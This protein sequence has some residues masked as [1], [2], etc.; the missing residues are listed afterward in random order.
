MTAP[1]ERK[2]AEPLVLNPEKI[3]AQATQIANETLDYYSSDDQFNIEDNR[4][5]GNGSVVVSIDWDHRADHQHFMTFQTLEYTD[6][7]LT[8]ISGEYSGNYYAYYPDKQTVTMGTRMTANGNAQVHMV[9]CDIS[10]KEQRLHEVTRVQ[11][12]TDLR[13][14]YLPASKNGSEGFEL[15]SISIIAR[16]LPSE[17]L[18]KFLPNGRFIALE[19]VLASTIDPYRSNQRFRERVPEISQAEGFPKFHYADTGPHAKQF[20]RTPDRDT[21]KMLGFVHPLEDNP[22]GWLEFVRLGLE[23]N[24]DVARA[25]LVE[26]DRESVQVEEINDVPTIKVNASVDGETFSLSIPEARGSWKEK[27]EE[28]LKRATETFTRDDGTEVVWVPINGEELAQSIQNGYYF[29]D[30]INWVLTAFYEK[31]Y[32]S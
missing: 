21:D 28:N 3:S 23:N 2:T 24:E 1:A 26:V 13:A 9:D 10:P 11:V 4:E 14:D 31:H 17:D 18:A 7:T 8:R 15:D 22:D 20:A 16:K 27:N 25:L 5:D 32:Q 19:D 12:H 29:S 30:M 6:D